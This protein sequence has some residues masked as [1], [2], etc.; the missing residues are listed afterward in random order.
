[1]LTKTTLERKKIFLTYASL[2]ES[3]TEESQGGSSLTAESEVETI[4]DI[5][6]LEGS[7]WLVHSTFL[8]NTVPPAPRQ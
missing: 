8:Y 6:L 5:I 1:M 7:S 2:L 4:G 3:K